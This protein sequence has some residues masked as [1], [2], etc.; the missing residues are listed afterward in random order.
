MAAETTE[1]AKALRKGLHRG[2]REW[3]SPKKTMSINL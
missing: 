3:T 2:R 1:R